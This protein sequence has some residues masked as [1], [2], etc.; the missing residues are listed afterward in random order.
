MENNYCLYYTSPPK[1]FFLLPLNIQFNEGEVTLH[2]FSRK[3]ILIKKEEIAHF[4]ISA[5]EAYPYIQQELNKTI[6]QFRQTFGLKEPKPQNTQQSET[7][8]EKAYEKVTGQ[9]SEFDLSNATGI[10]KDFGATIKTLWQAATTQDEAEI[11]AAREKMKEIRLRLEAKGLNVDDKFEALPLTLRE[12]YNKG[13]EGEPTLKES[14]EKLKE[15]TEKL[16]MSFKQL[17]DS[18]KLRKEAPQKP[19]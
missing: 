9:K 6:N 18:F 17:F 16:G 7:P 11:E 2:T 12:K 5:L 15:T 13:E 10:L 19:E 1:L 4:E 14:T 3:S 8:F